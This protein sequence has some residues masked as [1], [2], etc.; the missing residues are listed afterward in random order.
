MIEIGPGTLVDYMQSK[1][2]EMKK[3]HQMIF[4]IFSQIAV[5][6]GHIVTLTNKYYEFNPSVALNIYHVSSKVRHKTN[7]KDIHCLSLDFIHVQ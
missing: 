1:F 7:I 5:K 2:S 3:T 4:E 6:S